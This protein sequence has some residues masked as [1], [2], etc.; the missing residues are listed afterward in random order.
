M[1]LALLAEA[2]LGVLTVVHGFSLTFG[3]LYTAA[4]SGGWALLTLLTVLAGMGPGG[5]PSSG[6]R[7][8]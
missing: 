5:R 1:A 4:A 6:A 2:G 8:V 3:V 7:T